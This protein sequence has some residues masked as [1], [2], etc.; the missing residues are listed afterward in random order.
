[1]YMFLF[2]TLSVFI[3]ESY[4][5][6][7]DNNYRELWTIMYKS[8]INEWLLRLGKIHTTY[9]A[10]SLRSI[11][12]KVYALFYEHLCVRVYFFTRRAN[13]NC[14]AKRYALKIRSNINVCRVPVVINFNVLPIY[15]LWNVYCH[16]KTFI[17]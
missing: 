1:V 2:L 9:N 15:L 3:T 7:V 6:R 4:C 5:E 14:N 12:Y 13:N 11:A 10:K 16:N 8:R 17:L